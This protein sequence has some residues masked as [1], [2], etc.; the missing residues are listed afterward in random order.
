LLGVRAL[1]PW[2]LLGRSLLFWP[3]LRRRMLLNS[4]PFLLPFRLM[5]RCWSLLG[6]Y[7]LYR[8]RG[9]S[10]A[11]LRGWVYLRSR[12]LLGSRAHLLRWSLRLSLPHL[13]RGGLLGWPGLRNL[14]GG[15]C[16]RYRPFSLR[17][18]Q[19]CGSRQWMLL[20]SRSLHWF[21]PLD[22]KRPVHYHRLRLTAVDAGKL[23]AV[24][25]GTYPVLLLDP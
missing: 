14:L 21:T 20:Y 24:S 12:S 6:L 16:S 18:M 15:A 17:G 1:L 4:R 19:W 13:F 25:A 2:L 9:R 10:R 7:L 8:L 3:G 11:F 22:G 23:G 5:L